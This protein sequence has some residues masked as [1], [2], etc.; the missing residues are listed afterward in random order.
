MI[1]FLTPSLPT[2]SIHGVR[3]MRLR[4]GTAADK[5]ISNDH[6]FT[7]GWVSVAYIVPLVYK[8]LAVKGSSEYRENMEISGDQWSSLGKYFGS[9]GVN[10]AP[11]FVIL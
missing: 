3:D 5:K 8:G 6:L 11:V 9:E 1:T 10:R 4:P 2:P 7:R